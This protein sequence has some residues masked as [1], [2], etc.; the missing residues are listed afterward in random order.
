MYGSTKASLTNIDNTIAGAGVIYVNSL[1]INGAKGVI[2]A[3][4]AT[5]GGLIVNGTIANDGLIEATNG[6]VV[7]LDTVD[8]SG[9]GVILADGGSVELSNV[10]GGTLETVGGSI[11]T[12]HDGVLD[13]ATSVVNNR[14]TLRIM[15]SGGQ[16]TVQGTINNTGTIVLPD[17]GSLEIGAAGVAFTGGGQMTFA[18]FHG[19]ETVYARQATTFTNVDNNING[20]LNLGG[21]EGSPAF[22]LVN[23]A[24]G[25]INA[26]V[27]GPMIVDTGANTVINVGLIEASAAGGLVV[28]SAI[29]NTG[30]L[31][32]VSASTLVV[33]GAV[34]GNGVAVINGGRLIFKSSFSEKVIFNGTSGP[35]SASGLLL[36][37]QSQTYAGSI[38]N[39]AHNVHTVLDLRDIAFVGAGEATYSGTAQRGTLTVTDGTHT[40]HIALQGNYLG[41]VFKAKSDGFGGTSVFDVAK[42]AASH[43]TF[44]AAAASLGG[45][46]GGAASMT[47]DAWRAPE[48]MLA[49]P[50]VVS[51]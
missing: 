18:N 47:H 31:K 15:G 46:A 3:N 48:P 8:G 49:K 11:M 30:E 12:M 32:A 21:L 45:G 51:A 20:T 4:R 24:K 34:S 17:L 28:K 42:A 10:I 37:E 2:D 16:T 36:L 9:G 26:N 39:F 6:G 44:V 35:A 40:S 19:V 50:G 27:T 33:D 25:I 22:T 13:G 14:G 38:V 41:V 29:D 23:E 5:G 43:H 7:N 1:L